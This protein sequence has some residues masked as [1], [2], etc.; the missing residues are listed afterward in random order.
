MKKQ[1]GVRLSDDE[2]RELK[3]LI[4]SGRQLARKV[5]RARI[6][7]LADAGKKDE[8]IAEALHTSVPTVARVRRRF[9]QERLARGLAEQPRSGQP[10]KLRGK[11]AAHIT[12]LA[13]SDPPEGRSRWTLRLLADKAIE[14]E[15]VD[16]ISHEAIRQLL[17]KTN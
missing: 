1:Y 3:Q 9:A 11:V 15:L 5:T 8:E 12:S 13:C 14:L 4:R 7:L 6:L 17:K 2:R 16:T 10:P